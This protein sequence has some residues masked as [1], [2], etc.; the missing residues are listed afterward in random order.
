MQAGDSPSLT[1]NAS[2]YNL[3]SAG[4]KPEHTGT[5]DLTLTCVDA[6]TV[7][8][9]AGTCDAAR[10]KWAYK[11]MIGPAKVDDMPARF[12]V[13]G[14][15]EVAVADK[16]DVSAMLVDNNRTKAGKVLSALP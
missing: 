3:G 6:Y 15:G 7:A 2:V 14:I 4:G 12:I 11:G 8:V 13:P 16:L 5:L 9:P 1:I 10:L